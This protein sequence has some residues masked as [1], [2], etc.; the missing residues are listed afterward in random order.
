ML[1]QRFAA[2]HLFLSLHCA[3]RK[4]LVGFFHAAAGGCKRD[5]RL[6]SQVMALKESIDRRRRNIPPDR[7]THKIVS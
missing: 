1:T 2:L 6:A 5:N 7:E 3:G 4:A